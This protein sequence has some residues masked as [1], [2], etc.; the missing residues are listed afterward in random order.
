MITYFRTL[1]HANRLANHRLHV[2]CAQLAEDDFR[3]ARTG[4]FPSLHDT[5]NHILTVDWYYLAALHGE[6]DQRNAFA[7]RHPFHDMASLAAAQVAV[8]ERLIAWCAKASEALLEERVRLERADEAKSEHVG[9]MLMHLF[10]HQ[11]HHRGQAHA[12]L[13]GTHVKPP[14]LDDFIMPSDAP[15]RTHDLAALGWSEADLYHR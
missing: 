15:F 4:F 5:L 1:A 13:A 8:D 9:Y 10:T 6:V 7:V 14:Q 2:A 3:A 12:M 11:I